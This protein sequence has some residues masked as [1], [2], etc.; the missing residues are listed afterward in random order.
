[1]GWGGGGVCLYVCK[2][3]NNRDRV[4]IFEI[5]GVLVVVLVVLVVVLVVLGVVLELIEAV[6]SHCCY[7]C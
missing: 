4:V 6:A 2:S 3:L 1:M 7:R 5:G